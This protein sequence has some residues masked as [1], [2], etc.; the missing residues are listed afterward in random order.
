MTKNL[1]QKERNHLFREITK[2]YI[3]EGYSPRESKR[4]AKREIDEIME[5]KEDFVQNL[6]EEIYTDD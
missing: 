4:F 3:D 1:W 5:D 6:W 2:Q